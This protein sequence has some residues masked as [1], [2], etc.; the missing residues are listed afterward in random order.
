MKERQGATSVDIKTNQDERAWN[1]KSQTGEK[2][3]TA[4]FE[5]RRVSLHWRGMQVFLDLMKK[6][7]RCY[8]QRPKLLCRYIKN[9]KR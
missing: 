7:R 8:F 4:T 9:I 3:T 1:S 2:A 5:H 6:Y